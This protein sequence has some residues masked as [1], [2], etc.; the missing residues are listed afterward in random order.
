MNEPQKFLRQPVLSL[1]KVAL[2]LIVA[3]CFLSVATYF[4]L[5]LPIPSAKHIASLRD[6]RNANPNYQFEDRNFQEL[7]TQYNENW[8]QQKEKD[9]WNIITYYSNCEIFSPN[10][11]KVSKCISRFKLCEFQ[12]PLG[13][14]N[15]T[16]GP[17]PD[18]PLKPINAFD[19]YWD[20][21]KDPLK[22]PE[23]TSCMNIPDTKMT[24][25]EYL[26]ITARLLY[27]LPPIAV[28]LAIQ[29]FF[30]EETAWSAVSFLGFTSPN[31]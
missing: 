8:R 21:K 3:W 31:D 25:R 9:N 7:V 10:W 24:L 22:Y 4:F 2:G 1:I 16:G 14:K 18:F 30:G 5:A 15:E 29:P 17:N 28:G 26:I 12:L 6:I 23:Y 19:V 11:E 27:A 13:K 20:A